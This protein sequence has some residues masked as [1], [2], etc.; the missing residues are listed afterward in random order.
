[1]SFCATPKLEYN[2]FNINTSGVIVMKKSK[3]TVV[4][5]TLLASVF[6]LSACTSTT[7]HESTGQMVDSSAITVAVKAKLAADSDIS[8][9]NISVSTFKD[10]VTLRGK[11]KTMAQKD[12][13]VAD[14]R[15]VAGVGSVHDELH[16]MHIHHHSS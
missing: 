15:S 14:A 1:L 16:V 6:G 3:V 4:L 8:S 12:K 10:A 11:V 7:T 5:A 9:L 13:A 2:L